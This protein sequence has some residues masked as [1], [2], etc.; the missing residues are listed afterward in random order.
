MWLLALAACGSDSGMGPPSLEPS[1]APLQRPNII[2]VYADDMGWAD[3]SMNGG[4][5]ATPGIDRLAREGARFAS[6]YVPVPI[7]SPSRASLLTGQYPSDHGVVWNG[8]VTDPV[9]TRTTLPP[10]SVTLA[11]VLR[12]AGYRTALVG[13]WGLIDR[14]DVSSWPISHG[15]DFSYGH[16][17]RSQANVFYLNAHETDDKASIAEQAEKYTRYGLEWLAQQPDVPAFLYLAHDEPHDPY[18]PT[19]EADVQRLDQSV[20]QLLD[21]LYRLGLSEDTLVFFTSDNGAPLRKDSSNAPFAGG[22][23]TCEE[24][25]IRMPTAARWPGRIQAGS[26]VTEITSTL[27]LFPTFVALARGTLPGPRPGHDISGLLTGQAQAVDGAEIACWYKGWPVTLRQG[28]WKYHRPYQQNGERTLLFDLESDPG[29][30]HNV[31]GG[32][33]DIV[34]RLE[35][36]LRE[37]EAR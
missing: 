9:P 8:L 5:I 28:T 12:E 34:D 10:E 25:G 14:E 23:T 29:E 27:D 36:R 22:K 3:A 17:G 37:L 4:P 31:A 2:L 7:C 30:W 16:I 6:F 21:G 1:P 15:F 33:P 18:D 19:R 13:K 35:T 20:S 26:L 24:G 32:H 11:E